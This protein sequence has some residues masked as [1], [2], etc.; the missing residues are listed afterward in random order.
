MF[1]FLI[2]NHS[3]FYYFTIDFKLSISGRF[4][5]WLE[6]VKLRH[7]IKHISNISFPLN[8]LLL[9]GLELLWLTIQP[10]KINACLRLKTCGLEWVESCRTVLWLRFCVMKYLLGRRIRLMQRHI[11]LKLL[12]VQVYR[13]LLF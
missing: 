1:R 8:C 4:F 10:F 5:L 12:T 6:F 11:F 2:H 13:S 7:L 9:L 3:S